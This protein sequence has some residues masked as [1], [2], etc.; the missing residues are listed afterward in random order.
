MAWRLFGRKKEEVPAAPKPTIAEHV[1][2]LGER[3]AN[4]EKQIGDCDRQ[5]HALKSQAPGGD[6][7]RATPAVRQRAVALLKRKKMYEGQRDSTMARTLNMERTAFAI[8]GA[9]DAKAY[10]DGMK[11]AAGE[12]K[13]MVGEIDIGEV[14][15]LQDEM[16]D[17][18]ADMEEVNELLGRDIGAYDDVSEAD[19]DAELAG[20]GDLDA[21]ADP[22][23]GSSSAASAAPSSSIAGQHAT[24]AG[25]G[26]GGGGGG[27][28]Y[29]SDDALRSYL[30]PS[31]FPS[32]PS[33]Y[34]VA[35][36]GGGGSSSS[37]VP[38]VASATK[39]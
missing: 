12:L 16:T 3:E 21:A 39:F 11:T 36:G 38:T 27:E 20:Y 15:D 26:G 2:K 4:L 35:A 10:V 30:A 22:A 9:K 28:A 8:E 32:V 13:A 34:P 6:F 7:R 14:E 31:A 37:R 33:G 5:L 18:L 25:G 24:A 19:L 1:A 17:H 23:L 29:A